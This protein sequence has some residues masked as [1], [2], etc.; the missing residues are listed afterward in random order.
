MF[1][2]GIGRCCSKGLGA[3]A[4][5]ISVSKTSL[6]LDK[7]TQST[8]NGSVFTQGAFVALNA[9]IVTLVVGSYVFVRRKPRDP[10]SLNLKNK[11]GKAVANYSRTEY[12]PRANSLYGKTGDEIEKELNVLFQW[13]GHTWDAYEVLDVPAGSSRVMVQK[14]FEKLKSEI[15]DESVPFVTAAYNAI[16]KNI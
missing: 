1:H 13:N 3:W 16:I 5:V 14:A 8:N 9:A 15:D 11:D 10:V 4:T 12:R 6:V 2:P 7:V